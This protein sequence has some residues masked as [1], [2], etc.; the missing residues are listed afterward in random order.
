MICSTLK[1][2]HVMVLCYG[3]IPHVPDFSDLYLTFEEKWENACRIAEF[4]VPLQCQ[5]REA[6]Y[7][8][9]RIKIVRFKYR[10]CAH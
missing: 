5:M 4:F 9:L 3:M 8:L 6:K 2:A 1:F 7:H 10:N